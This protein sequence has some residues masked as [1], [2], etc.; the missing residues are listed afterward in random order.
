MAEQDGHHSDLIMQLLHH[1]MSSTHDVDAKGDIFRCI[2]YPP[3]FDVIACIF[4]ELQ[5][6][7]GGGAY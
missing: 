3:S 2:I 4:L 1:V 6:W 5:R 7:W